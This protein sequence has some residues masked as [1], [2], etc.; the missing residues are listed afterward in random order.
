MD[1]N[2]AG[3]T[4][5]LKAPDLVQQLVA[6]VNAVGVTGQAG[7]QFQLLGRCLDHL[8]LDLELIA[9]HIQMQV[10]KVIYALVFL[11]L[12]GGT[13]QHGLD[14]GRD[15]LGVK[16][17]DDVVIR[18]QFKAKHLVI[19]LTLCGQHNDGGVVL[20][21]DFAAGLPAV[22][23]RHH[24]VQ[25]HQIRVQLVKL[26]QRRRAVV[27]HRHIVAFLYQ[28]QAE[29]FADI[30]IVIDDQNLLVCHLVFPPYAA[31]RHYL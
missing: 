15:L 23:H 14:A 16:G 24:N 17:L 10:V 3:I 18:A 19:G 21:A 4:V 1:V 7:Q 27:N 31:R 29:Q 20:A 22:H 8:A 26:R 25:Q 6:G 12:G 11:L 9:V 28:I 5:V 13:A 30:F 2:R